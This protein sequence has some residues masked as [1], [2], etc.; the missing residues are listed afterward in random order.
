MIKVDDNNGQFGSKKIVT[1]RDLS[2]L[3]AQ[4]NLPT[5]RRAE[6]RSAISTASKLTGHGM[7]D[8]IADL[9]SILVALDRFSPAMAG[10]SPGG[11][12]NLKSRL[13]AAFKL[14]KPGIV[15][16]RN[17]NLGPEWL[18]LQSSLSKRHRV[19]LSRFMRFCALQGWLPQNVDDEHMER[20]RHFL[21]ETTA[22]LDSGVTVR[23]TIRAWNAASTQHVTFDLTLLTEPAAKRT[24]YWVARETWPTSLNADVDAFLESLSAN[25][26]LTKDNAPRLKSATVSQYEVGLITVVSALVALGETLSELQS[27]AQ[28]VSPANVERVMHFLHR[29]F[30][31]RVTSGMEIVAARARRA[32]QWCKLPDAELVAFND[33]L[34]RMKPEVESRRGMTPK[35]QALIERLDDPQFRDLYLILP[36]TLMRKARSAK[37]RGF[38]ASYAR[39]A[40][41]I[42]ILQTC[43]FRRANLAGLKLGENIKKAGISRDAFWIIE[44]EPED[45]KNGV[46][47]RFQLP[48]ES[49]ELL[50]E[51]LQKWRPYFCAQPNNWLFPDL[52]GGACNARSLACDIGRKS[53]KVIGVAISPHQF[54]HLSAAIYV[55][56]NPNNVTVASEH[57]GHKSVDTTRSYY[58]RSQQKAAT[59]IYQQKLGL[60]RAHAVERT[61]RTSVRRSAIRK[62]K[63][64]DTQ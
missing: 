28:V 4:T 14:A 11:L 12:A 22:T 64:G 35:N 21:D 59:R 13:R 57:L 15:S 55:G 31:G 26:F 5:A 30:H 50:E 6:L 29:R 45:V 7:L 17:V 33:L 41:A 10:L 36:F 39:T 63:L 62:P 42:E 38:A 34:D 46:P 3:I 2:E 60:D 40:V 49:A 9:R 25:G 8:Q 47:L 53:K 58:L 51:Y 1:L 19:Q 32:A 23:S 24:G 52:K 43:S 20:Y 56:D 54:R 61:A 37:H 16:V 48:S 44:F 27:L 18:C